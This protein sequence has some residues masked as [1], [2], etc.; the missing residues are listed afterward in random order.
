MHQWLFAYYYFFDVVSQGKS[1]LPLTCNFHFASKSLFFEIN[2][3][4]LKIGLVS[5][6]HFDNDL[7]L[8]IPSHLTFFHLCSLNF[9]AQTS[10][11]LTCLLHLF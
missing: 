6:Q 8:C 2:E 11:T 4:H 9:I 1:N 10:S 7:A 3:S 5:F